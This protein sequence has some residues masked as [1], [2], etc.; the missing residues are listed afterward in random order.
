[1]LTTHIFVFLSCIRINGEIWRDWFPTD[2]SEAVLLVCLFFVCAPWFHIWRFFFFFFFFCFFSLLIVVLREDSVWWLWH[3]LLCV[4]MMLG[5]NVY[6]SMVISRLSLCWKELRSFC[7]FVCI[8]ILKRRTAIK[9]LLWMYKGEGK[10]KQPVCILKDARRDCGHICVSFIFFMSKPLC[11][12]YVAAVKRLPIHAFD[13]FISFWRV[14]LTII[15]HIQF[16]RLFFVI[17]DFPDN[18]IY[19]FI[20][21]KFYTICQ[22]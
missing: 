22:E 14:A 6:P 1:M 21:V 9:V 13:D 15:S 7:G 18:F 4:Q 12:C 2:R 5:C 17:E 16:G 11:L 10:Q 3:F 19:T 20:T 8:N